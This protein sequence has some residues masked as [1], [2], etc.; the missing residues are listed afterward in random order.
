MQS[1]FF[2]IFALLSCFGR[3]AGQG[4][5]VYGVVVADQAHSSS[6]GAADRS[7]IVKAFKSAEKCAV[8]MEGV[9]LLDV[10][11][12]TPPNR[13]RNLEEARELQFNMC[14]SCCYMGQML[15]CITYRVCCTACNTCPRYL[16]SEQDEHE[17]AYLDILEE[18]AA[19]KVVR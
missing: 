10:A 13:E 4:G 9:V 19:R 16:E 8:D 6:C 7:E 5:F 1:T 14:N 2:F 3:A 11:T 18:H 15:M 17:D 12:Y